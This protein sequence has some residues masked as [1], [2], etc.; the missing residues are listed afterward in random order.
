MPAERQVTG[1]FNP[2]IAEHGAYR[3]NPLEHREIDLCPDKFLKPPEP[4]FMFPK[5]V[6]SVRGCALKRHYL[7]DVHAP[8]SKPCIADPDEELLVQIVGLLGLSS[9]SADKV[10]SR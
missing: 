4:L 1:H 8:D 2:H 9:K 3:K 7:T 10:E 5:C 6:V